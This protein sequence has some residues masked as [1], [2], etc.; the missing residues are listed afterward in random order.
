MESLPPRVQGEAQGQ[1]F[2]ALN[3]DVPD[4]I[5]LPDLLLQVTFWGGCSDPQPHLINRSYTL[6]TY[7]VRASPP[8]FLEYLQD[9]GTLV[10]D[11]KLG[12]QCS[13]L[14][15]RCSM[16]ISTVSPTNPVWRTFPIQGGADAVANVEISASVIF[17][18]WKIHSEE[19]KRDQV[20]NPVEDTVLDCFAAFDRALAR[21]T[22]KLLEFQQVSMLRW[23]Y[24]TETR[25]IYLMV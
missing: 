3:L 18:S 2:L 5:G 8:T 12:D 13:A 4:Q 6:L 15:A 9:M 10:L 17:P 23:Q 25:N 1:F 14:L 20:A 19:V 21:Y 11:F 16:D 22:S 24:C 7:E